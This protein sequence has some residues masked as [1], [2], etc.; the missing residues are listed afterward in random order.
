MGFFNKVKAVANAV[1]G[2]GVKVFVECDPL[3][4]ATPMHVKIKVQTKDSAVKIDRV[5]LKIK[6]E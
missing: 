2:G 4:F 6:G 3:V 1:T 5:Y